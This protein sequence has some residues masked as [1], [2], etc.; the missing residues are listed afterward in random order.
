MLVKPGVHKVSLLETGKVDALI[1]P[2]GGAPTDGNTHRLLVDPKRELLEYVTATGIYP[3]NTLITLRRSTVAANPGLPKAMMAAFA[4]ARGLYHSELA[5]VGAGDHMG[6]ATNDLSEMG[7]FPDSYGL[8]ANR[9]S[10]EVIL[11]YCYEQG[12]IR[13]RFAAEEIFC[14]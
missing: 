14:N 3:I 4:K 12:L 9:A 11:D 5:T 2:A 6:V 8:E 1:S 13:T 10:I 7:L